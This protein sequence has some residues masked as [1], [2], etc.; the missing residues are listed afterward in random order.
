MSKRLR[1]TLVMRVGMSDRDATHSDLVE[2][3]GIA[4]TRAVAAV[5][6]AAVFAGAD[7]LTNR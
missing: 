6:E 1:E 2:I 7:S 4:R 3:D 5:A